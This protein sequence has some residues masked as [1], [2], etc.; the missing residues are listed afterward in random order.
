MN[1][2]FQRSTAGKATPSER[3]MVKK[4]GRKRKD[5]ISK[6]RDFL[7]KLDYNEQGMLYEFIA[8]I[9][10][11]DIYNLDGAN[12]LKW[13]LTAKI[14]AILFPEEFRAREYV[15][16]RDR[17]HF[18]DE[19]FVQLR[20]ELTDF[21]ALMAKSPGRNNLQIAFGHWMSH[22]KKALEWLYKIMKEDEAENVFSKEETNELKRILAE[23]KD[24]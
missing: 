5:L 6:F 11:I 23:L 22:T 24:F 17:I 20:Q 7:K 12:G 13:H 21:Q 8:S 16:V 14:R 15:D 10:G 9:R 18:E 4:A 1:G 3:R 19:Q 2:Y